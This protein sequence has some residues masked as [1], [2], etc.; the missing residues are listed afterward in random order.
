[1]HHQLTFIPR[2]L[3]KDLYFR[4]DN[5]LFVVFTIYYCNDCNNSYVYFGL[6]LKSESSHDHLLYHF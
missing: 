3:H 5:L 6:L 4:Y 2:Y 1:M